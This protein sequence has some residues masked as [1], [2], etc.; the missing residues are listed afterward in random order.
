[1]AMRTCAA[2]AA[3]AVCFLP[4]MLSEL[5]SVKSSSP[6]VICVGILFFLPLPLAHL[7]L[8]NIAAPDYREQS[9]QLRVR[10]IG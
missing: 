8:M 7:L 6:D 2:P 1:M 4:S 3:A 10:D 9:M 5:V